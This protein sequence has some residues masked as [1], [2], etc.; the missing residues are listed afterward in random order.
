MEVNNIQTQ[1][2]NYDAFLLDALEIGDTAAKEVDKSK[3]ISTNNST[4]QAEKKDW[5]QKI[6]S[7]AIDVLENNI[8]VDNDSPLFSAE[9]APIE[10]Y[11]EALDELRK[12]VDSDFE[13]NAVNAQANLTHSDILYLFEDQF[14]HLVV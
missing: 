2:A 8:Q 6:L 4:S 5:Q 13:K 14:D 1:T 7:N 11:A 3:E 12:L 9:S 10:S